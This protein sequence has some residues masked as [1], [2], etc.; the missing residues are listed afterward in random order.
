M[1][2]MYLLYMT[3]GLCGQQILAC[4]HAPEPADQNWNS[5]ANANVHIYR[6]L[7][8]Q[9]IPSNQSKSLQ[10]EQKET[11]ITEKV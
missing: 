7:Y 1:L 6:Q 11:E 4:E 9:W 5:I 2:N 8:L 10:M 3:T